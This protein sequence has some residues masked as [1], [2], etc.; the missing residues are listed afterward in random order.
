[1]ADAVGFLQ[2]SP[3]LATEIVHVDLDDANTWWLIVCERRIT[4]V[5]TT[6]PYKGWNRSLA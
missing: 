4:C 2:T 1:M 6:P 3:G 5:P